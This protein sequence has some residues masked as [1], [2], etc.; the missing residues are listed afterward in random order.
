[1]KTEMKKQVAGLG[2]IFLMFY[3]VLLQL[4]TTSDN[5]LANNPR[6]VN[7]EI[8]IDALLPLWLQVTV[9]FQEVSI[10]LATLIVGLALLITIFGVIHLTKEENNDE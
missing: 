7:E 10:H 5:T 9:G 2:V 6:V 8:S 1:M 3:I 4:I